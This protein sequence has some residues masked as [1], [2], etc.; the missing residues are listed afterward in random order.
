VLIIDGIIDERLGEDRNSRARGK[1]FEKFAVEQII[2]DYYITNDNIVD[3]MLDGR[4]DGGMDYAFIFIN[5]N[6]LSDPSKFHWPNSNI[7]LETI[8]ITCKHQDTFKQ[9][10]FG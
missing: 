8:I 2:K 4:D 3:S 7:E 1:A 6:I 10:P 9:S 5:G